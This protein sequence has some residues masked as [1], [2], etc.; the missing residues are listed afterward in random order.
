MSSFARVLLS[1]AAG[2][3]IVLVTKV[4][5]HLIAGAPSR[6]EA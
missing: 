5:R 2:A 1:I 4:T 3:A 6:A